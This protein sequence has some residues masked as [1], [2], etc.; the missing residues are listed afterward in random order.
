M[1]LTARSRRS[2]GGGSTDEDDRPRTGRAVVRCPGCGR[3]SRLRPSPVGAP[4]CRSCRAWLPWLV[5]AG[6][7]SFDEE[8]QAGVPVLVDFWASWCGPCRLVAPVLEALALS[9]AGKLK[10]VKVDVDAAPRLSAR[11]RVASIP[12]LIVLRGGE[13]VERYVGALPQRELERRLAPHLG[14]AA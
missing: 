12:T 7:A 9:H 10:V 3:A 1:N 13:E 2:R 6:D 5:D 14:A 11:F 8:I 4:R